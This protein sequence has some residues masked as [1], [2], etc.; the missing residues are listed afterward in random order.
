MSLSFDYSML[1]QLSTEGEREEKAA[2]EGSSRRR[3]VEFSDMGVQVLFHRD[4]SP[5]SLRESQPPSPV[6]IDFRTRSQKQA[7]KEQDL[8]NPA[9]AI[10]HPGDISTTA[11]TSS[12]VGNTSTGTATTAGSTEVGW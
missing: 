12:N 2:G 4:H 1:Q 3:S 7:H 10:P 6:S 9:P 5:S 8:R 11:A